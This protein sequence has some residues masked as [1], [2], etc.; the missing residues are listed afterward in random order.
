ME[1]P[2][3]KLTIGVYLKPQCSFSV[4]IALTEHSQNIIKNRLVL[5]RDPRPWGG[6]DSRVF[7]DGVFF[8]VREIHVHL[9]GTGDAI[10]DV[11]FKYMRKNGDVFWSPLHNARSGDIIKKEC[12]NS[13]EAEKISIGPFGGPGGRKFSAASTRDGIKQIIIFYN[14]DVVNWI[15]FKSDTGKSSEK[16]GGGFNDGTRNASVD[17]D[18][19]SDFLTGISG[20]YGLHGGFVIVKSLRFYTKLNEYGP[21]GSESGTPF[22]IRRKGCRIIGIHGR[23]GGY[24][25]SVGGYLMPQCSF[26]VPVPLTEHSQNNLMKNTFVLLRDPGP[27]GGEDGRVFDDGVFRKVKEIHVHLCGTGDAIS[28]VQFKYLKKKGD[29][30]WS[31]VHGARGEDI[32]K[33]IDIDCEGGEFVAGIEGFYGKIE[34][35]G[36][37]DVIRSLTFHTS[38]GKYGP[39]GCEIGKY[40]T[41]IV[42][43]GK[44][45]GF[46]G[47]SSA[48]LNAIGVHT[49]YS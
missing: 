34:M 4:P 20:T 35:S 40:F 44:V 10:S 43:D 49:E 13:C 36:G 5:L 28:G 42:C 6:E 1:A 7:E 39:L 27:W 31:H 15:M 22:S 47:K 21:F 41:S 32:V 9:C 17:I 38:K 45:V 8:D 11:Q 46:F 18:F 33:K 16:Y 19:P 3:D 48:Y 25:D 26:S 14:D 30:F 29:E 12:L 24:I 2:T 23:H 37:V